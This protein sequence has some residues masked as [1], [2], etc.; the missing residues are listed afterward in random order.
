M[1]SG[2]SVVNI[3]AAAAAAGYCSF[4]VRVGWKQRRNRRNVPWFVG[5]SRLIARGIDSL[6]VANSDTKYS[7]LSRSFWQP[8]TGT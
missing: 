1:T 5:G 3:R 6:K 2:V 7:L 4:A 8:F